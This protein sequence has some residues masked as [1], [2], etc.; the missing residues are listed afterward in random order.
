LSGVW[1]ADTHFAWIVSGVEAAVHGA[2]T[3]VDPSRHDYNL[4]SVMGLGERWDDWNN[5]C[6]AEVKE[7]CYSHVVSTNQTSPVPCPPDHCLCGQG[8]CPSP[9]WCSGCPL[10]LSSYSNPPWTGPCAD[11]G[12]CVTRWKVRTP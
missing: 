3:V 12:G 9:G 11:L 7:W 5:V 4:Y 2:V 10:L 6:G 1:F 8:Q